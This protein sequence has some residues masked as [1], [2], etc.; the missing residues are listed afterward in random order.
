MA[1]APAHVRV[2]HDELAKAAKAA[3]SIK[4]E[5][6]SWNGPQS[7]VWI[8]SFRTIAVWTLAYHGNGKTVALDFRHYDANVDPTFEYIR[9][10]AENSTTVFNLADPNCFAAMA[11]LIDSKTKEAFD[12]RL[13]WCMWKAK[14]D[15][16]ESEA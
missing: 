8:S 10:L 13:E 7:S 5:L 9:S 11:A 15:M 1:K 2:V 14:K 6:V 3:S 16:G 4:D 12:E